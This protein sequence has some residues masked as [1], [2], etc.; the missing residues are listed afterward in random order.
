MSGR[1]SKLEN[2]T[3]VR[4]LMSSA[5]L[6]LALLGCRTTPDTSLSS[7]QQAEAGLV[8]N[9]QSWNSIIFVKPDV[10]G[11]ANT[12]SFRRKTFTREG[13]VKLLRNLKLNRD[14]AVV[15]LDRQYSPD[16]VNAAGGMDAIQRFLEEL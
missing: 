14:F 4:S 5:L 11:T 9:F 16:P 2:D 12:M 8:L 15:V 7:R 10:T 13:V 3:L 6:C 1:A